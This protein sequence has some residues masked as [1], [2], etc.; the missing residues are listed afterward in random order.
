MR[1]S[2]VALMVAGLVLVAAFSGMGTFTQTGSSKNASAQTDVDDLRDWTIAM[3]W[4]ADNSLDELTDTFVDIWL[5]SLTDRVDVAMSVYIDG[6]YDTANISTVT[7]E[8]WQEVE[9]LGEANSSDPATLQHFLEF[10]LNDKSLAAENYCLIVQD[11]GLGYLGLCVDD[12]EPGRPWMSIHGFASAVGGAKLATGKTIDVIE[13]DACTLAMAEVAYELRD[14]A[15]YLVASEKA[16]PFDGLNYWA[17]LEGLSLDSNVTPVE[18]ACK[19]V[20]DYAEWYSA[21]LGTYPTLYPYM[22]DFASL[23]VMNLSRMQ[24]LADAFAALTAEMLPLQAD[25]MGP[26]R[27]SSKTAISAMWM[28]CMG[29]D[30]GADI[31]VMFTSLANKVQ[32]SHPTLAAKCMLV[33][34]AADDVIE[35]N[36]ASWRFRGRCTGM[37]VFVPPGTGIYNAYWDMTLNR[38]YDQLGLDFVDATG[39]DEIVLAYTG[40]M[41][42]PS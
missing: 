9:A 42:M 28:N 33:V 39:W 40:T 35:K 37:S 1:K 23:S 15:G 24:P 5:Q 7:E 21:P 22:Q 29:C 11:H 14:K 16:V 34:D 12:S 13:L 2:T 38:V 26:F 36:W 8:G 17:L 30:Y 27:E 6:L 41:K 4:D 19:M 31:K 18:L 25:L 32:D 20:D 3:Y 10:T